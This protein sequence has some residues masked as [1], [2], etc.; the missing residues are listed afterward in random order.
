[1]STKGGPWGPTC[2][3]FVH[4][5]IV[6]RY[7]DNREFITNEEATK[8]SLVVPF[9]AALGYDTTSPRE[10]R[11]EYTAEFTVHDGKRLPDRMDYAIFNSTGRKLLLV[12]EVK[13]L[14]MNIKE[15]SPQLARYMAQLPDLRFGIM[16]DGCQYH[17][18]SDLSQTN[19]MDEK[20]FFMFALDDPKLDYEGVA[21]FLNKFSRDE[22]NAE[23]LITEAE[24]SNL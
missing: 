17:F 12:V 23:S 14:G 22:F 13:S 3:G 7:K 9:L 5:E 1:M 2:P 10:V 11:P 6:A 24:D 21:K 18:Y 19:V 8:Q 4:L 16:T 15:R 20:P